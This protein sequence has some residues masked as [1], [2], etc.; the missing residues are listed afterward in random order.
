MAGRA[1]RRGIDTKGKVMI[2]LNSPD[3]FNSKVLFAEMVNGQGVYL[4]SK[5]KLSYELVLKI[6]DVDDIITKSFG[7]RDINYHVARPWLEKLTRVRERHDTP[8]ACIFADDM[9]VYW[10][11]VLINDSVYGNVIL[12]KTGARMLKVI[13]MFVDF[14]N[15]YYS[16]SPI[17][18]TH[19]HSTGE[20]KMELPLQGLE[21]K[22]LYCYSQYLR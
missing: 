17:K 12:Y 10:L 8:T 2:L 19:I 14:D 22:H 18:N 16:V 20:S 5:F 1:G 3:I 13:K 9:N 21:T 7:S 6:P 15:T 11:G 4:Q